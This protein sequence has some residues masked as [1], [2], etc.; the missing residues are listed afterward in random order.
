MAERMVVDANIA[1]KWFLSDINEADID[2]AREILLALLAGDLELHAPRI[3]MYEVCGAL[4]KA[5]G[6]RLTG[7]ATPRISKDLA[8]QAIH[9]LFGL[10]IVIEEASENEAIAALELAVTFSKGHYD[11]TYLRLANKLNCKWC[12]AD[13]KVL[14]AASVNFP[15]DRVLLLSAR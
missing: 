3:F 6:H 11:M 15:H 8:V 10:P 2:K 7:T 1:I 14:K 5:C 13:A 9:E 12:T 4:T